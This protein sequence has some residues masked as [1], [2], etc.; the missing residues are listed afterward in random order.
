LLTAPEFDLVVAVP[1]SSARF[2]PELAVRPLIDCAGAQK[3]LAAFVVPDAPEALMQLTAAGVPNFRTPESCAD[4]IAAA[5]ARRK[6]KTPPPSR[7]RGVAGAEDRLSELDS[8]GLLERLGIPHAAAVAVDVGRE[9]DPAISFP[10]PVAVK[11]LS[12]QIAHKTDAGAVVLGV[13][14]DGELVRAIAQIRMNVEKH[15]PGTATKRVLVQQMVAGVAEVLVGYR[16]DAQVGPIVMLAA[17]G[18][19]TEIYRDR[20][21][22]LAPIDRETARDMI[23]EVKA[24]RVLGG[25]R[26]QAAGDLD[27]LVSA[28]VALSRLAVIDDPIVAEA[29]INPLLVLPQGSGVVAVDASVRLA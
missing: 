18:V 24:L 19:L 25:Y 1:G 7:A 6:P 3:P 10:Y 16:V 4:S 2:E 9:T 15:L 26:G 14:N 5:F 20:A 27:A 12:S 17:G 21:L 13:A 8:Y 23:G 28:I 11:V 29:E 22:R